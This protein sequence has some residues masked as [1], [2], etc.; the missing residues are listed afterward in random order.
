[1]N[2]ARGKDVKASRARAHYY[3]YVN[4]IGTLWVYTDWMP[5]VDYEAHVL[6]VKLVLVP[7]API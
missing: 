7:T 1:M 3:L 2:Q 4:K 6:G 5:F